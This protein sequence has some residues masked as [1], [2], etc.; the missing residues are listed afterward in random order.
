MKLI[1][2][3]CDAC[4]R[5]RLIDEAAVGGGVFSCPVCAAQARSVPGSRYA[6]ED[7]ALYDQLAGVVRDAGISVA[8]AAQLQARLDGDESQTPSERLLKLAQTLPTLAVLE[9][10]ARGD[11][12]LARKAEGMLQTILAAIA[13]QRRRSGEM[14]AILGV[15]MPR[16]RSTKR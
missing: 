4:E 13:S 10:L 8:N 9:G 15:T 6:P 7:A 11:A 2:T 14:P 5:S 12:A 1:P 3:Y 16:R